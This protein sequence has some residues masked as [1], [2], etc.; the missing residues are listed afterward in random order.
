MSDDKGVARVSICL[1]PVEADGVVSGLAIDKQS[2]TITTEGTSEDLDLTEV[3]R[4]IKGNLG[5]LGTDQEVENSIFLRQ[6][7]VVNGVL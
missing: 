7:K 6:L 3:G 2:A 5:D 4:H 1:P